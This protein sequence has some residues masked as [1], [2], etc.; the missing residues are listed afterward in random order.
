[1]KEVVFLG[2]VIFA[3]GIFV[4]PMKV[5]AVLKWKK[6]TNVIKICSF[7]GFVGY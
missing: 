6:P 2:H 5:K 4:N 7:L 1:M 3:K